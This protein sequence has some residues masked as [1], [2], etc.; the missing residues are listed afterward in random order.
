M[1]WGQ[2][3]R[4][5]S[6]NSMTSASTLVTGERCLQYPSCK[7]L[8]DLR[9][10]SNRSVTSPTQPTERYAQVGCAAKCL[11]K[12]NSSIYIHSSSMS[13][14]TMARLCAKLLS[15]FSTRSFVQQAPCVF[16][17]SFRGTRTQLE[18]LR[19]A[20]PQPVLFRSIPTECATCCC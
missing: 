20:L 4:L 16:L 3:M 6:A 12:G 5:G 18:Y 14:D 8:H 9:V 1:T 19:S 15:V 10:R 11:A 13:S 7:A 2:A 17:L